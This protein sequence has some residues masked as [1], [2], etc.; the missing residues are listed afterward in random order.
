MFEIAMAIAS[1]NQV[2]SSRTPLWSTAKVLLVDVVLI[3][4]PTPPDAAFPFDE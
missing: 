2:P 1:I 4:A 3:D